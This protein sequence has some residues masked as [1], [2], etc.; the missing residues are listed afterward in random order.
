MSAPIPAQHCPH[1]ELGHRFLIRYRLVQ[2]ALWKMEEFIAAVI[3]NNHH[4]QI[5]GWFS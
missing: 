4:N 5:R 3:P 1:N 2:P